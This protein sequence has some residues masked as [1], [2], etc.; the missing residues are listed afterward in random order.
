MLPMKQ[1]LQTKV[2]SQINLNALWGLR[3]ANTAILYKTSEAVM[4]R[5]KQDV[6]LRS[7]TRGWL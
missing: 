4:D 1:D 5:V 2:I 6:I 7:E 3:R